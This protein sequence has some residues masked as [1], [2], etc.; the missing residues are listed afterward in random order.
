MIITRRLVLESEGHFFSW[1]I[2]PQ[3]RRFVAETGLR[4][5]LLTI[6]YQH[7]TG[8][9]VLLEHETGILADL[10]DALEKIAPENGLYFHHLRDVDFNGSSHVRN[11]LLGSSLSIPFAEGDLLLG[12]YQ[13]IL[14]LDMQTSDQP[15][16]LILQIMGE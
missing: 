15:R 7:T 4:N 5:G 1:N 9:V 2:T 8:A 12:Q 3:A 6:L 16:S 10:E 11:A 13:D 14:V